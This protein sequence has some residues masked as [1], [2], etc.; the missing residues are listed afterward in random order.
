MRVAAALLA[1]VAVVCLGVAIAHM[2]A[3]TDG[4]RRGWALRAAALA[5]FAGAV[6]LNVLAR[7]S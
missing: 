4:G 5:C 2:A 3:G 1:L 7:A 6:V